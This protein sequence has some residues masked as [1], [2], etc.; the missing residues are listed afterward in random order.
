MMSVLNWQSWSISSKRELIYTFMGI[1]K[2]MWHWSS[3]LTPEY[4][5]SCC[6]SPEFFGNNN[7]ES[8][9]PEITIF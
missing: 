2:H 4:L 3:Q 9:Q 8:S 1:L 6:V 7:F 5:Q